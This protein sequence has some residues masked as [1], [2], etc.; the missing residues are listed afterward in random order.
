MAQGRFECVILITATLLASCA[1]AIAQQTVAADAFV[2][3]VGVNIHLHYTD[4]PYWEQFPAIRN[5]LIELGVRHVRDGLVEPAFPEYLERHAS[6]AQAGIKGTFIVVPNQ[7]TEAWASFPSRVGG[8]LE[9]YEAPN[10]YD[11]AP[12][13]NWAQTLT[14]TLRRLRSLKSDPRAAPYPV[15]GPSLTTEGA[16]GALGD[17]SAYFD[18]AN[19]HNYFSGR[20]PGSTG[21]GAD[22]Y[23]SIVWN[24]NLSRRYAAAKPFVSTETG[25]HNTSNEADAVPERV[26]GRYMPRLLLE[27]MRAGIERTFIYE[28]CDLTP[29][30]AYGLL[31]YDV[32]PKPAF[33]AVKSLLA[34][35]NDPGPP[36]AIQ[37]LQ[38]TVQGATD[39]LRHMAF[40]KRNGT[41]YLA[42]WL[43]VPSWDPVAKK[44]VATQ[45][46]QV[47][48][49]LPEAMRVVNTHRWQPDGTMQTSAGK[50]SS[51]S[52]PTGVSDTLMMIEL[53]R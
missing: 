11:K 49:K 1:P 15:Y 33:L 24:L 9:A 25:Y 4:S 40:Q 51:A 36:F 12:D 53:A 18:Y 37:D 48:V 29:P 43:A 14:E 32:S 20:H 47:V 34:L 42:L 2:D 26:A 13:P 35:L 46:R 22:G 52:L 41:Y 38:Y 6:L 7:S 39:D 16:F 23:G 10:E 44:P 21:W 50:S 28:L 30:G 27:Q 19:L 8:A 17:V 45:T 5:R 31:R 3:S